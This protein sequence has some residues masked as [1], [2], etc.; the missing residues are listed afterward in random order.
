MRIL[1]AVVAI[2][3]LI[4]LLPLFLSVESGLKF[5]LPYRVFFSLIVIFV[6][7]VF[8]LLRAPDMPSPKSAGRAVASVAIVFVASIGLIVLFANLAPQFAFESKGSAAG[9]PIESGK[10]IFND[11][12]AGCFLC[13]AVGGAGGTR[14]PDLSHVATVASK[15]RPAMSAED[16]L[17][18]S[19]L[20]PSAY[21]VPTFDNIMPPIAQRLPP[22]KLNDLLTYLMTLK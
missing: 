4:W 18:E 5:G 3:A 8:Y 20:N 10:A 9:T 21:V 13:H 16:Y 12:N 7:F 17:K 11:P 2:I 22:E 19:L 1:I 15:R 6:G 14:G